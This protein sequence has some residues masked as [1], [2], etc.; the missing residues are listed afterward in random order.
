ME[1]E[2][3]VIDRCRIP[4]AAVPFLQVFFTQE[5]LTVLAGIEKD[6]FTRNEVSALLGE[7]T[8]FYLTDAYQRGIVSF[9]DKEKGTYRL[10]T[11]YDFL[12]VFVVTQ[13]Q[14]YRDEIPKESRKEIDDWYFD[15][16][17]KRLD[18]DLTCRPTED[19]IL[20]LA[21]ALERVDKDERQLYWTNC[22]CKCLGGE[23]GLPVKVCLSYRSGDNSYP[24][25][26]VSEPVS[27][28]KAKQILIDADKAGLMHTW[29]PGGFCSCC[30]DC[31]Y[32]FRAQKI[33]HSKRLWP[34]QHTIVSFEA[35]KCIGC[36]RCAK[37]CPFQVPSLGAEKKITL[38]REECV[39]CGLCV[40][41]CPAKALS[42]TPLGEEG[43]SP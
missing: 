15:S 23:C 39:G 9:E 14:R 29:N 16:Y 11:F 20:P 32:L 7:K 2:E 12:D 24:D 36:G 33:R 26:K 3:K 5:D 43:V 21:E 4:K 31:C 30:S 19:E 25:R 6:P 28:E 10:N 37:R 17:V 42:L 22:D 18:Q 35:E 38:R 27:K 13:T 40:N 34:R 8:D 41:T 1:K